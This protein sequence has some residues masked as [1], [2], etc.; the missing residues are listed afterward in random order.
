[1]NLVTGATGLLGTHLMFELIGSGQ[2]VRA[3]Y[4]SAKTKQHCLMVLRHLGA[5]ESWLE[6]IEW[7]EGDVLN[8][9]SLMEAMEGAHHVY[10]CAAVVSYHKKERTLM[11]AVNTEGTA[12]VVNVALDKGIAKLCHVSSIAAL[13]KPENNGWID[14]QAE[15]K[16]SDLNTHYAITKYLSEMEVWRGVQEGLDV[17]IVN[18]G[19]V[20]GPG[21]FERSSSRVFS[22]IDAGMPF[23]P[24]GGTGFVAAIDCARS[25][26]K[27]MQSEI[28]NERYVLVG[29]NASMK[30]LFQSISLHLG[31]K[32]PNQEASRWAMQL[33]RI[34]AWL[35]EIF[36]GKKALI[37]RET[38][39]NA[40]L[41]YYYKNDKIKSAVG[42]EF[43][44]LEE[45]VK[46]TASL[47]KSKSSLHSN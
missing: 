26:T 25:M 10:H 12:N 9:P 3:L 19:F 34:G 18:P 24:P 47:Y 15:W 23:Y 37:T 31:K 21:D 30:E 39:M 29:E 42:L 38:L 46:S 32:V 1:M 41:R 14:E 36:T 27:L 44:S 6:R 16:E 7:F 4:R 17:V 35:Q 8:I 11:Y 22:T 5:H 33:A 40:S 2:P 13:G 28:K 43:T 20:I 45:A